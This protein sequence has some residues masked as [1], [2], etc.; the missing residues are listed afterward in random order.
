MSRNIL[1]V[2]AIALI[3]GAGA[4]ILQFALPSGGGVNEA[5]VKA[6][7]GRVEDLETTSPLKIAYIKVGPV[8]EID[9]D[10]GA[11]GVFTDVVKDLR[12]KAQQK[13]NDI[14]ELQ[15]ELRSNTISE[16][17]FNEQRRQL[18]VELLQAR[19]N[20]DIGT[21]DRMIA[22]P[23]FADIR[24]QLEAIREEAQPLI[25]EVKNLVSTVRVGVLNPT[26]VENNY[27]IL[28]TLFTQLDQLLTRAATLK[29]VE[30]ANKVAVA[31]G[32][33][34]VLQSKNIVYRN[35]GKLVD[36]TDFVKH[37]LATYL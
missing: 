4:L 3:L 29:I 7:E 14:M 21:I 34:L 16:E 22:A 9:R 33:D 30:A 36:I 15:Q 1:I 27:N 32:Y 11:F 19:L 28:N 13:Q 8:N 10:Y 20:I 31:N 35:T 6:L 12:E 23:G 37:E 5:T 17:E 18:L 25:D 24:N 2:A 26:E